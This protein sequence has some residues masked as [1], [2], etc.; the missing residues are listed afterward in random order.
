MLWSH[1]P[2]CLSFRSGLAVGEAVL[3]VSGAWHKSLAGFLWFQPLVGSRTR[4]VGSSL[5]SGVSWRGDPRGEWTPCGI[6]EQLP[7]WLFPSGA[8]ACRVGPPQSL[9]LISPQ[10]T[11]APAFSQV[12]SSCHL[13]HQ[14]SPLSVGSLQTLTVATQEEGKLAPPHPS[15]R[16]LTLLYSSKAELLWGWKL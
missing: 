7:C 11:S 15:L 6:L 4:C 12:T 9:L 5:P 1:F 2:G 3:P 13:H 14:A 16:N 10:P 8:Q